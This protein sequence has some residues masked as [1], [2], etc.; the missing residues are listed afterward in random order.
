METSTATNVQTPDTTNTGVGSLEPAPDTAI[1]STGVPKGLEEEEIVLQ[2]ILAAVCTC[3]T[4]VLGCGDGLLFLACLFRQLFLRPGIQH[5]ALILP[6][7]CTHEHSAVLN[8][9]VV[10][11]WSTH[12]LGMFK[13]AAD[14]SSCKLVCV[15]LQ[16]CS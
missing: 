2:T 13:P 14:S 8:F 9:V 12:V 11:S 7:L 3:V 6:Y 5:L 16:A 15:Q 1:S 4:V 10:P